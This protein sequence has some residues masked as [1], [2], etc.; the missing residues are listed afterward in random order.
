MVVVC[1]EKTYIFLLYGKARGVSDGAKLSGNT[2]VAVMCSSGNACDACG[3]MI[4][5]G[6]GATRSRCAKK[7]FWSLRGQGCS[8]C[9]GDLSYCVLLCR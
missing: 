3:K 6:H 7:I 9:P 1:V 8:A 4:R 2:D 5:R